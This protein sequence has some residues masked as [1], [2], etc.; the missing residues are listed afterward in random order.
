MD[1]I[2]DFLVPAGVDR[3][4]A[5]FVN[6]V[7]Q[8]EG[9]DYHVAGRRMSFA[10]PL[11]PAGRLSLVQKLLI[12]FC[13]NVDEEGDEVDA[14]VVTGTERRS[15]PLPAVDGDRAAPQLLTG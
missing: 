5:V 12:A 4:E 7:R 6:G 10:R 11:D 14:I 2:C 3:V 13:A 8:V 1:H 15:V 9:R